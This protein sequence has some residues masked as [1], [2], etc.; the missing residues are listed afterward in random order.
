M[1]DS[2]HLPKR[3]SELCLVRNDHQATPT[4]LCLLW[5]NFL[6]PPNSIFTCWDIWEVQQEKT[7]A[8]VWALQF[9]EEKVDLHNKGKPCLLVGGIKELWEEMVCYLSISNKDVFKGLALPEETSTPP[10]EE[11]APQSI[12]STPSKTPGGHCRY[13]HGTLSKGKVPKQVPWFG[14]G[15]M[16]LPTHGGCG[17]DSSSIKRPKTKTS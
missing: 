6:L 15:A 16:S 7:V 12:S 1:W 2:F 5:K 17:A 11:A 4:P 9:W 8:Y 13:G 3:A 14:Q 10:I